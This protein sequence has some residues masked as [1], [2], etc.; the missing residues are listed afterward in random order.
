MVVLIP[1]TTNGPNLNRPKPVPE[2]NKKWLLNIK[3]SCASDIG[4]EKNPKLQIKTLVGK[5]C[6]NSIYFDIRLLLNEW[7]V[8]VN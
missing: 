7:D 5:K 1:A 6:A 4:T 8:F 3:F 2:D